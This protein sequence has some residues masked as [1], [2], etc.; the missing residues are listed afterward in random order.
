[1]GRYMTDLDLTPMPCPSLGLHDAGVQHDAVR[2]VCTWSKAVAE[3][4]KNL[5]ISTRV[6]QINT[7]HRRL[8]RLRMTREGGW[9]RTMSGERRLCGQTDEGAAELYMCLL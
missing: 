9:S 5:S 7:A 8:R 4:Q 1:M 6:L 3:A 2:Q